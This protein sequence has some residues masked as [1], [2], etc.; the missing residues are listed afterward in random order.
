MKVI[1]SLACIFL[2]ALTSAQ[3]AYANTGP[4]PNLALSQLVMAVALWA[5]TAAGGG[6]A[7]KKMKK[8]GKGIGGWELVLGMFIIAPI[9]VILSPVFPYGLLILPVWGIKRGWDLLQWAGEARS[10]D[11]SA[12]PADASPRRLALAGVA[13]IVLMI[14]LPVAGVWLDATSSP[15][16]VKGYNYAALADMRNL[17]TI[18]VAH[19]EDTEAYPDSV[20]VISDQEGNR[21]YKAISA[22]KDLKVSWGGPSRDVEVAYTKTA[23]KAYVL[24]S[25]HAKGDREYKTS[26]DDMV[27]YFRK[28][29]DTHAPWEK[30]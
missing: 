6:Y 27:V 18:L 7:V 13:L 12:L 23:A 1:K 19:F 4:G 2:F 15:Y 21:T 3:N 14:A 26:S 22:G 10:A 8:P 30:I 25:A 20:E 29:G 16:R 11:R 5:L 28:K 17:K 9:S 24:I